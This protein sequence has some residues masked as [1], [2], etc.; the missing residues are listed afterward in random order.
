[1]SSA[2]FV[3]GATNQTQGVFH[4]ELFN[5]LSDYVRARHQIETTCTSVAMQSGLSRCSLVETIEQCM[6]DVL[7]IYP[8]LP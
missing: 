1:M 2:S 8:E 6:T 3:L 5:H 4:H 7:E